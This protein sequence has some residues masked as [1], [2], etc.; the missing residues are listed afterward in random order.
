MLSLNDRWEQAEGASRG[1]GGK[2]KIK[3]EA[4]EETKRIPGWQ[5][6]GENSCRKRQREGTLERLRGKGG[7]GGVLA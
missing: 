4:E 7:G 6:K 2:K 3:E 1:R 5:R